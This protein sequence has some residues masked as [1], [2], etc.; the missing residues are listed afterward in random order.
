MKWKVDCTAI[1]FDNAILLFE[2]SIAKGK[3]VSSFSMMLD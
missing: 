1:E 3:G 2:S